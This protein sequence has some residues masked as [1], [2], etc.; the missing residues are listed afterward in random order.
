MQMFCR[1]QST[2]GNRQCANV[3]ILKPDRL[4]LPKTVYT[5]RIHIHSHDN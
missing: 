3:G 4:S 2:D 5:C 1:K